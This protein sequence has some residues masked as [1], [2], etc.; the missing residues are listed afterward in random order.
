[1]IGYDVN[2]GD[3]PFEVV[4]PPF[5]GVVDSCKFFVVDVVIHISVFKRLGVERNR[6][7][8]TIWGADG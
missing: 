4:S 3:G 5:E 7:V 1:M 8:V 2:G 6:M